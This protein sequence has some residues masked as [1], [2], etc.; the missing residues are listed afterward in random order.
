MFALCVFVGLWARSQDV[1]YNDPS[2]ASFEEARILAYEGDFIS[3]N[4]MLT[5]LVKPDSKDH[6]ARSLLA[7]TYS[8]REE[9][10]KARDEFNILISSDKQDRSVWIASIKNELYANN[11]AT[12][13]GL[14]NKALVYLKN[15]AEV[16]R[17][18]LI[19]EEGVLNAEYPESGW[20]NQDDSVISKKEA[21]LVSN[22]NK[23]TIVKPE[24]I[25]T[26]VA[27]TL[28][29]EEVF[30]NKISVSNSATV[31]DQRYDTYLL[32]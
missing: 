18:Q 3:A 2:T 25:D 27:K 26:L 13:I 9:Y 4:V 5:Q 10:D 16:E 23:S 8:W 32:L 14:A 12:A 15:D 11:N 24:A 22:E 31:F 20:F 19:A 29:A 6:N 17:L 30:N 1:A 28:V 21:L 7:S